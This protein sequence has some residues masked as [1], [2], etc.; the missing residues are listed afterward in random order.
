[1]TTSD[2][3]SERER[4]WLDA[5]LDV[6]ARVQTVMGDLS[7]G[8]RTAIALADW[9]P[10]TARGLPHPQYVDA[11]S[12]L[13]GIEGATA[14]PAGIAL[15]AAFDPELAETYGAAV[16]AE[17]RTG[18]FSV[19]LGRPTGHEPQRP[20]DG[21]RRPGLRRA[22]GVAGRSRARRVRARAAGTRRDQ[23][24]GRR[25]RPR[26]VPAASTPRAG[27]GP[28]SRYGSAAVTGV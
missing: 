20:P 5:S 27:G 23:G 1:M 8:E 15:A 10:L 11:G 12:G 3:T 2:A 6:D 25:S 26:R 24:D 7:E 4:P 16:G 19:L 28:S 14:F 17:V 13:R 22:R 18:A 21:S 9:S